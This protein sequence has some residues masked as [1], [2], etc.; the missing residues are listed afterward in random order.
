MKTADFLFIIAI[1]ALIASVPFAAAD[2]P[3]VVI[4]GYKVTPAVMMPGDTGT[5]EITIMNTASGASLT[6]KT[7]SSGNDPISTKTTDIN[8]YIETVHLEGKGV[9]VVSE[10]FQRVGDLGPG[11]SFPITF[12]IRAPAGSGIYF[13][14]VWID[15]KDGRST[16]YPVPVN[17]NT[18]IAV[19]K[20][21]IIATAVDAPEALR[22]GD[23][24]DV[25]IQIRNDGQ[26]AADRVVVR[27]GNASTSIASRSSRL[28]T[29]GTLD[30]GAARWIDLQLIS[31]RKAAVGLARIPLTVEYYS[32][33]GKLQQETATVEIIIRGQPEMGI[34][35]IETIPERVTEREPFI[36]IIRVENA[37]TGD[38]KTVS[39][40]IDLPV[41]GSHEAFLG[42]IK[43]GND[44]PALFR[45]GGGLGGEMAYM[46]TVSYTDEWGNHTFKRP[47]RLTIAPADY[48]GLIAG[49]AVLAV[50]GG[51][52]WWWFIYRKQGKK[53]G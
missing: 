30:A 51:A 23:S 13:P 26:S 28:Y 42:T 25:R 39:A 2:E 8:V 33:D 36:L 21:A 46:L 50:L 27:V 38:A 48:S 16:R 6:E 34:A 20:Q 7:G 52:A 40:V 4:T 14:E 10:S 24:A 35:S 5:L 45:F 15:T 17:V 3:T 29:I 44:A 19:L 22:P 12:L 43:P 49:L 41:E 32:I 37:G 11:Q 9:D 53:H 31:D 18:Q 1:L 47:L